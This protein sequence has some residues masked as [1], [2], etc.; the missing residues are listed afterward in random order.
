MSPPV[1]R[2]TDA[3]R[4]RLLCLL[5]LPHLGPGRLR[6]LRA[7]YGS[8]AEVV[9]VVRAGGVADDVPLRMTAHR[10]R[11]LADW[12]ARLRAVDPA[13]VLA[14]HRDLGVAVLVPGDHEWPAV[15]EDDPE[16]PA[17]LCAAGDV[18][19]L[20]HAGVAVIGTRSCTGVGRRVARSLGAGLA[21]AGVTTVSG[22][23]LGIDG[24]A[25]RGALDAG[26]APLGVVACG[27]DVPY[28]RRNQDLWAA[29]RERGLLV[30]EYPLGVRPERWRFPARNRIIAA[31]SCAVVVVE[32]KQA[33]GS[34]LTVEEAIARDRPVYAVPGSVLSPSSAGTNQ[35]L[36]D[37]CAPICGPDD[38]LFA[39]GHA[40]AA[41]PLLVD[42]VADPVVRALR[43]AG[44]ALSFDSLL[45]ATGLD[46]DDL[47]RRLGL[48]ELEGEL[49]RTLSGYE[50]T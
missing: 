12:A 44:A 2:R 21:T 43:A 39:I 1:T 49:A 22:L 48:L 7:A 29:V 8:D 41:S 18:G 38:V 40:P 17:L 36:V 14:A 30:S 25:H 33:G 46:V 35:L 13:A 9:A 19:L 47:T 3:D 4:A 15:L 6:A 11:I 24:A 27:L 28:P 20:D 37:G 5:G 45:A 16:P 42:E 31:L 23:A 32:S 50:A 26:G 34:M 10:Q